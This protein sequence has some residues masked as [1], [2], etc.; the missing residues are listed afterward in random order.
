[1]E[2]DRQHG[3]VHD[4][5]VDIDFCAQML[6]QFLLFCYIWPIVFFMHVL[7]PAAKK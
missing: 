7:L 4:A 2:Y 6:L 5:G 3:M 1:M